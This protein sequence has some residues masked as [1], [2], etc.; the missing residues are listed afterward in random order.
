MNITVNEKSFSPYG[1]PTRDWLA[2]NPAQELAKIIERYWA[3]RGHRVNVRVDREFGGWVIRSD[4]RD[5]LP[6]A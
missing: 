3:V 5:G 2:E 6:R 4:M 1:Y